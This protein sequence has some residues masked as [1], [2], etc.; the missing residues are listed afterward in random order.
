MTQ[1]VNIIGAGLAGLLA[2]NMLRH[3][4]TILEKQKSLPNNHRALLRFRTE[5]FGTAIGIP[6]KKVRM[7]KAVYGDNSNPIKNELDYSRK[8]IG[9]LRTDR[10]LPVGVVKEDRFV[11]PPDLIEQMASVCDIQYADGF[12]NSDRDLFGQ[13]AND[14]PIISTIPMPELMELLQ[15]PKRKTV[16]F[17]S[18]KGSVVTADIKNCDAYATYYFPN[19]QFAAYRASIT[20]SKL[21]I[22]ATESAFE[23]T[24][25]AFDDSFAKDRAIYYGRALGI[26]GAEIENA[27]NHNMK[28]AKILPIDEDVRKDFMHWATVNFNIYSL[29]RFATWRP[30]LLLDDLV[31][32]VS[33]ISGWVLK[34]GKYNAARHWK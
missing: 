34:G 21:I 18:F 1:R 17:R 33:L 19:P 25:S 9:E 30:G 8:T 32:D 15:Y 28:Y 24:E 31:N 11:A 22:E 26:Y 29:G 6:F 7:I 4:A 16:E 3:R 27:Q 2:G 12:K 10:S 23:A 5:V 20:G 13:H 14:P